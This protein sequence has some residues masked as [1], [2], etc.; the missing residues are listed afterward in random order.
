MKLTTTGATVVATALGL[1]ALGWWT[2]DNLLVLVGLVL[3]GPV[4]ADA[5]LGAR[6]LR[7]VTVSRRLPAE[8]FAR[9]PAHGALLLGGVAGSVRIRDR[10]GGARVVAEHD[11][12]V[13]TSWVFARR[14]VTSLCTLDLDTRWPLGLVAHRRRVDEAV[15]L[16]V[17]PCPQPGPSAV[18][19]TDSEIDEASAVSRRGDFHSLRAYQWGDAARAVHWR[20]SAR[21]GELVVVERAGD[22]AE[23]VVVDLR[24][25]SGDWERS[26]EEGCGA[27]LAG[28][29]RGPVV[30]QLSGATL[31]PARDGRFRAAALRL[32]ATAEAP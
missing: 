13:R 24:R 7:R 18:Q 3:V 20:T 9:T 10:V 2:T 11:G 31:G 19:P 15:T 30:L 17:A 29:E 16:W 21:R 26:L 1:L 32:L 8:V 5:L 12:E 25:R 6:M 27:L 14:G 23:V 4:V 22:G 28:L